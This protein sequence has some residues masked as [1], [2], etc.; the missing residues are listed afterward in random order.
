MPTEITRTSTVITQKDQIQADKP[1]LFTGYWVN[2]LQGLATN[3]H[4]LDKLKLGCSRKLSE[5]EVN[6]QRIS[7]C[8]GQTKTNHTMVERYLSSIP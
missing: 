7:W 5:T 4:L 6:A 8:V 2:P 1:K 3:Q